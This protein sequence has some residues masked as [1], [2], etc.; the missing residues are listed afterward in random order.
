MDIKIFNIYHELLILKSEWKYIYN[1]LNYKENI[2]LI[3]KIEIP[4]LQSIS[5]LISATIIDILILPIFLAI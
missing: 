2:S 4:C 3:N 1:I 5:N